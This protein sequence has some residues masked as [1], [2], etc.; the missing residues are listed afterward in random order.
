MYSACRPSWTRHS[1]RPFCFAAL[2]LLAL[3]LGR[4]WGCSP[5]I[6]QAAPLPEAE[7]V[8]P[9]GLAVAGSNQLG[10]R[11]TN[12]S[13][14]RTAV[15]AR[16]ELKTPT[17]RPLAH[18]QTLR[19]APGATR[20]LAL[21][22]QAAEPGLYTG[23]LK[24]YEQGSGRL[25]RAFADLTIPVWP[26]WEFTPDRSYYTSEAQLRFRARLRRGKGEDKKLLVELREG[27]RVRAKQQLPFR[28]S[29][30]A[31][32]FAMAQLPPGRYTLRARLQGPAGIEDS[33]SYPIYKYPPAAQEIKIDL[34]T[35]GLL[36]EGKPFFPLGLYWL[37]AEDLEELARLHFNC[38]DY[39]YK[40]RESQIAALMDEAARSGIRILLELTPF[41][42]GRA[43]PDYQAITATVERYR[44]HPALLAWYLVDEPAD[45]KV[46][47][48]QL[49]GIYQQLRR[50]DPY[51]PV[52]LVNN[53]PRTYRTYAEA[54]D[55]LAIDVYPVPDHP[56][57]RVGDYTQ[58]ARWASQGRKPVWLVAQAF[59]GVEHWGRPPTPAELR[60]MVFQGL[61][62][63]ASG[64]LFYRHCQKGEEQIQPPALWREM[65]TL[66]AELAPLGPV[67]TAPVPLLAQVECVDG[68]QGVQAMLREY[69][70]QY[71]LFVVNCRAAAQRTRFRLRGLPSLARVEAL[72]QSQAPALQ[73][74]LLVIDLAALGAGIYRLEPAGT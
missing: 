35:Q 50:S 6:Q 61:V 56:L 41:I 52:Y 18:E 69:R 68:S 42:R 16:L 28:G 30:A 43:E 40:L 26:R 27:E 23:S 11:L 51:H 24:V 39:F 66:A 8:G 47:S 72:Y 64:L 44:R 32:S 33:L 17:G 67:L 63:G 73:D 37:Q 2:L 70:G 62:Q 57:T 14:R 38:G 48:A 10:V 31:G 46:D 55:I 34:Y 60:N 74:G 45:A 9:P 13:S 49:E 22:Y 36:V 59:G 54:S 71:Y 19:L 1:A 29:E 25:I 53:R 21:P 5:A 12:R 20:Q 58:Q 65:R 7:L 3:Q 15:V 4:L